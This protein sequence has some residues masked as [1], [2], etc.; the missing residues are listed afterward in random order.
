MFG[1]ERSGITQST[2]QQDAKGAKEKKRTN[3]IRVLQKDGK[4]M[5]GED[6]TP[7]QEMTTNFEKRSFS[8]GVSRTRAQMMK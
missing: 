4:F 2:I 8:A 7:L 5:V 6:F 3:T 1:L